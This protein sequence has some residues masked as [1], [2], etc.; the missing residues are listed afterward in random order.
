MPA[1]LRTSLTSASICAALCLAS[2]A[3]VCSPTQAYAQEPSAIDQR[4]YDS[5]FKGLKRDLNDQIKR[6]NTIYEETVERRRKEL[7]T[8]LGRM[9]RSGVDVGPREQEIDAFIADAYTRLATAQAK[10]AR[11]TIDEKVPK[12]EP[13]AGVERIGATA[14]TWC[15]TIDEVLERPSGAKS[16]AIP[17]S[18]E[19]ITLLSIRDALTFSCAVKDFTLTQQWTAA[20]RQRLSNLLGLSAKENLELI[21]FAANTFRKLEYTESVK[22]KEHPTAGACAAFP[23]PESKLVEDQMTRSLERSLLRCKKNVTTIPSSQR[24]PFDGNSPYWLVDLEGYPST[25]VARLGL[26]QRLLSK[27]VFA[28]DLADPIKARDPFKLINNY[29]MAGALPIERA[30]VLEELGAAIAEIGRASC[31]ERV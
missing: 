22:S 7:K 16:I 1:S 9:E 24:L 31:R 14:P 29:A 20:Y 8:I 11:D 28:D 23:A 30:A 21:T 3:F 2:G 5:A 13:E 19:S 12:I 26:A 4:D 18:T 15:A 6:K 25:H 27:D 17:R 10:K